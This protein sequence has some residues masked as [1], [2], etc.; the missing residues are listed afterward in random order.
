MEPQAVWLTQTIDVVG[1]TDDGDT[2]TAHRVF[3]KTQTEEAA[4]AVKLGDVRVNGYLLRNRQDRLFQSH[5][6]HTSGLADDLRAECICVLNIIEGD[7]VAGGIIGDAR[8]L[9]VALPP[10]R[11]LA[12]KFEPHL[13]KS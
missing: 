7:Q 3:G 1:I 5:A 13:E 11:A 8:A 6:G 2:I 9:N 4:S 10:G 12:F